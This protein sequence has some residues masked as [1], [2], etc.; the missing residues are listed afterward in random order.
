[1]D[2]KT[3]IHK[4]FSKLKNWWRKGIFQ[5]SSRITYDVL[6]NVILFFIIIGVVGLFFAGGVGAGY[7]ASL[8]KDEEVRSRESMEKDIYNYEETSEFYFANNV[9]LGEVSSDLYRE[10]VSLKDVSPYVKDAIIA[11]E[12]EYF[13][14]HNGVV[15]K[16]ILRAIFQ[17]ATNAAVKT[18]GSTLTQQLIKN[19]IL[20]NEVSFERKAKEILLALR[21]EQ[22]FEKDEILEAYLNIVPF[23][24]NASGENIAGI[25]TA[26][27]GIFG[28]DAK[29]INLPQAAFIA[30][31]PQ[32]PSYYTPFLNGGNKKD[33]EGLEPGLNRMKSV[34]QR[35]LDREYI[36]QADYEE[37]MNYDIVGDF[38]EPQESLLDQ[39]PF[40]TNEVK[41]RA[42]DILTDVL[43]KEDGYAEED[44]QN[45]ETL[46]E[47]YAILAERAL[48]S[49]G[50]K[51][52]TTIDKN[53]YDKFQEITANYNN[54]GPDKTA[55]N[56]NT[57]KVIQKENPE[58]GEMET[59][60]EPVQVGSILI[61]NTT[62]KIIS[63][64]GGRDFDIEQANHATFTKRQ[65]GSTM[66]PLL[67]YAPAMEAGIVQPGS[68][69]ADV[70][71][72]YSSGQIVNN[73]TEGN[74][75]LVSA[76]E[77]LYKSHNVPAVKTYKQ[78]LSN[79]PANYLEKMGFTSL[80]EADYYIESIAIGGLTNGVTVE[81]NT[82]AYGTFGNNGQFVDAYM[83]DKIETVDGEVVYQ[84]E[85]EPVDVFTPQ[86]NYLML[87]MMRDVL[88]RGTATAAR[89]N[90]NNTNVD[91]AGKTGTTNGFRDTWFVA[92]NPNVTLGSWMGYDHN[93]Q[94]EGRDYSARNVVFWA[95]L[96]NAATE[97]NPE[98]MAPSERFERPGGIV[99]R[100]YC[101]TSGMLPSNICSELGLVQSD[102]YN[103]NYVPS[104]RDNSLIKDR[105]VMINGKAV[106]AGNNTPDEFTDGNGVAFNPEWIKENNYDKLSDI[107]QLI[108][109]KSGVWANI[110]IPDT[111][112]IANDGKN[113]ATPSSVSK[114]GSSLTW[115]QS[116]SND[117]VGYRIFRADEPGAS[118][119]LVG[120]TTESSF[121][122]PSSKAVYHVKAVDYFGQESSDSKTVVV[123]DFSEPEPPEEPEKPKEKP[124]EE[125][126]KKPEDNSSGDNSNDSG[127]NQE[128]NSEGNNNNG[129]E[130]S[131][132]E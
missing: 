7:F 107:R 62:G 71:T 37:A 92:T 17:E 78:I 129:S 124:K 75:G 18:G 110:E 36:S 106:I 23:G 72:Y 114:S 86:T 21:L 103:A 30:G 6:W 40:L 60:I 123:G 61:D 94:L 38:T 31:L 87:D 13:E 108:P 63:F 64:V 9:F 131:E 56:R 119:R 104:K 120:N 59:V 82:N 2:F 27:Q 97:S 51:I 77:A 88:T 89:A 73:Y 112:E 122:I 85:S 50:Y 39:Y 66:K 98:L 1:M 3:F 57:N 29:D 42:I 117:V 132:N 20:T 128:S 53:I 102:I 121:K 55:I 84:H 115:N 35:M 76:R 101:A 69:I 100:S 65:N 105:Y 4:Y 33:E 67:V 90:L 48:G 34:L 83:I 70:P 79:N 46:K 44:I 26:A 16:A 91:W 81:E 8:V 43:A 126:K 14:T 127:N 118:F 111:D 80:A 5:K 12:D 22:F 25:Q 47:E 95:Q 96:V 19:Q 41:E 15:P 54:Y 32:S 125:P 109:N 93:M 68:I 28:V 58:T 116:S 113:P 10:E 74:Y 45:S 99:S 11:T 130:N 49:S 52:H 24:R